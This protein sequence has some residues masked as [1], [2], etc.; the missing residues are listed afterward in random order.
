M[1][2]LIPGSRRAQ[3]WLFCFGSD[4]TH[5]VTGESLAGCYVRIRGTTNAARRRMFAAFGPHWSTQ[6]T[7]DEAAPAIARWNWR[8]IQVPGARAEEYDTHAGRR[9]DK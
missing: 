5:P 9:G 7:E 8:E 2:K 1:T 3:N 4:H 6:Y